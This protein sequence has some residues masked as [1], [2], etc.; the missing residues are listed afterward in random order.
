[1]N[2]DLFDNPNSNRDYTIQHVAEEF[3]SVC[4]VTGQP[5][6]GKVILTYTA[7]A[8]CI[9]LKSYKLYLQGYRNQGIFYEAV[10]N[11]ILDDLVELC[12]PRWM[13]VETVWTTRGGIHSNIT[14]EYK[15]EG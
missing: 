15:R 1:M 5:D 9:E 11:K 6:F 7:D 2:I 12:A 8:K 10:T 4:P 3:T 13:K 14:A